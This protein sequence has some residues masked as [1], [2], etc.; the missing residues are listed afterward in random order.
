M[1]CL[2]RKFWKAGNTET[3]KVIMNWQVKL[4][5]VATV[6]VVRELEVAGSV[7][8][9]AVMVAVDVSVVTEVVVDT[10]GMK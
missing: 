8:A 9:V 2:K 3:V 6:V 1:K 10:G 5:V 4:P 7:V